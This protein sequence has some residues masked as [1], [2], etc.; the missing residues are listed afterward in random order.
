VG[1]SSEVCAADH[2]V[3]APC[4]VVDFYQVILLL[5]KKLVSWWLPDVVKLI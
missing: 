5:W 1:G 3:V 2:D 4:A